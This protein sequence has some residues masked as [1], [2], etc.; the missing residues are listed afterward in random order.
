[1]ISRK[2]AAET[3][4][5]VIFDSLTPIL[6]AAGE[7]TT[8][9]AFGPELLTEAIKDPTLNIYLDRSPKV[10]APIDYQELVK[11]LQHKRAAFITAEQKKKE[12]KIEGED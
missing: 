1:M 9:G 5:I 11:N 4:E 7:M 3:R 8:Y 2:R 6:E 12:P 10:G